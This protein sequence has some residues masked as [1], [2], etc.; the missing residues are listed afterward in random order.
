MRS[1]H[2]GNALEQALPA[3]RSLYEHG[4][5]VGPLSRLARK[6]TD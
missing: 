4:P 3:R 5:S 6:V 1:A 2:A